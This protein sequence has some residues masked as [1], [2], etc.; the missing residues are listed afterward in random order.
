MRRVIF[1]IH[2]AIQSGGYEQKHNILH[3]IQFD[4]IPGQL[5][6]LIGSNGA[7]KSTTIQ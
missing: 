5:V 2:I 1:L 4:L 7:G 3:D 6:G